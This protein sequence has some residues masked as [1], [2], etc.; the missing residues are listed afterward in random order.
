MVHSDADLG[1]EGK[2]CQVSKHTPTP[3]YHT[4]WNV[5]S[6]TVDPVRGTLPLVCKCEGASNDERVANAKRIVAC[7][8]GCKGIED[9]E[10]TVPELIALVKAA[11]GLVSFALQSSS[12]KGQVDEAIEWGTR[13]ENLL[14]KLKGG[15]K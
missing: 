6:R 10:T 9:P 4:G 12:S 11:E 7:V 13:S 5:C 8:N 1:A 2:G 14:A 3:W 15:A